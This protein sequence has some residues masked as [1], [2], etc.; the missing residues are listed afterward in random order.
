[1]K[2][3]IAKNWRSILII[4]LSSAL[5]ALASVAASAAYYGYIVERSHHKDVRC[6]L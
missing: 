6:F 3:I 4:S 1:M 2:E 5:Y